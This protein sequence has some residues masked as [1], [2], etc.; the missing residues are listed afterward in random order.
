VRGKKKEQTRT[1][2]AAALP[3]PSCPAAPAARLSEQRAASSEQQAAAAEPPRP[4]ASPPR[5][6][7]H[8]RFRFQRRQAR[9]GDTQTQAAR[10]PLAALASPPLE[11]KAERRSAARRSPHRFLL[12]PVR[13][14]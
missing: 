2:R 1:D 4:R 3:S 8:H 7:L 5:L 9:G 11:K 10:P 12:F 6:P 13:K 14:P